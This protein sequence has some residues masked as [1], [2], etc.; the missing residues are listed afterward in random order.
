MARHLGEV[1]G[2]G[3]KGRRVDECALPKGM[4]TAK[5]FQWLEFCLA[6]HNGGNTH[7]GRYLWYADV[8]LLL[9]MPGL[10]ISW[11]TRF[12]LI[13]TFTGKKAAIE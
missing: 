11:E 5:D 13:E 3:A 8:G 6:P 2:E 10:T 7:E 12:V 4:T 9:V 1:H